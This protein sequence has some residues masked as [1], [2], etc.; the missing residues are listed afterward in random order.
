MPSQLDFVPYSSKS[1][2]HQA[3]WLLRELVNDR[4]HG[5]SGCPCDC[6]A[7][8]YAAYRRGEKAKGRSFSKRSFFVFFLSHH[9]LEATLYDRRLSRPR[10][11]EE[12]YRFGVGG[13]LLRDYQGYFRR[14]AHQRNKDGETII[15]P[16]V[17]QA[18]EEIVERYFLSMD[19]FI[20]HVKRISR[21][22]TFDMIK[23][24]EGAERG[25]ARDFLR[26][27]LRGKSFYTYFGRA[28][29]PEL[30]AVIQKARKE[31]L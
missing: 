20:E 31:L 27:I 16:R 25:P 5:F 14:I 23:R 9:F 6:G 21:R 18:G 10:F 30:F 13:D 15:S 17:T 4:C 11:F 29:E 3:R 7:C 28:A 2:T 19:I 1:L 24:L 12:S 22:R 26:G 8:I